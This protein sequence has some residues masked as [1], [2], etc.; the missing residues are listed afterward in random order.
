[1]TKKKVDKEAELGIYDEKGK[2]VS[3]ETLFPSSDL[4]LPMSPLA[5]KAKEIATNTSMLLDAKGYKW[6]AYNFREQSENT[7]I[8]NTKWPGEDGGEWVGNGFIKF[9]G[10]SD[11]ALAQAL[12]L[13][14]EK[15]LE[16]HAKAGPPLE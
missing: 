1:M 15:D 8:F 10:A 12:A 6:E 14:W 3:L 2:F 16:S 13:V 4:N 5:K 7:V 11:V 9:D